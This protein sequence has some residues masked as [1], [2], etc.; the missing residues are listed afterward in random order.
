MRIPQLVPKTAFACARLLL[1]LFAQGVHGYFIAFISRPG[2]EVE[3]NLSGIDVVDV[4]GKIFHGQ[5]A[6]VGVNQAVGIDFGVVVVG[7]V[8]RM[9]PFFE[10][11]LYYQAVGISPAGCPSLF[12]HPG[13]GETLHFGVCHAL[14]PRG[15]GCSSGF[16][17][18][19]AGYETD[20]AASNK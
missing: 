2:I 1:H 5:D 6:S 4:E 13:F 3:E 20:D 15:F 19:C 9:L 10:H 11:G 14:A 18:A 16:T 8:A 17:V 7:A 12:N